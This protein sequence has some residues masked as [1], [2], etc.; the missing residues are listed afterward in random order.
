MDDNTPPL[1]LKAQMQRRTPA[2]R[3][4]ANPTNKALA[5]AAFCYRCQDQG[6]NTPHLTKARVRDCTH[7]TCELWPHRGWQGTT[8]ASHRLLIPDF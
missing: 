1:S 5:I 6:E 8:T 3:A 7:K 4:L 2:E